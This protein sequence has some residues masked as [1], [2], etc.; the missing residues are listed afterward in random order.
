MVASGSSDGCIYFYD[1]K[2]ARL[3]R[4]IKVHEQACTDVAFH[5]VMPNVV[6]TCSWNGEVSVFD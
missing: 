2:S 4:K 5:P 6:A 3:I 1:S